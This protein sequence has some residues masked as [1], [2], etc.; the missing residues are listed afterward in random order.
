MTEKETN[1]KR[2]IETDDAPGAMRDDEELDLDDEL[3]LGLSQGDY[4]N[5]MRTL[6]D[7]I[8]LDTSAIGPSFIEQAAE[9]LKEFETRWLGQQKFFALLLIAKSVQ[10]Q[11]VIRATGLT[12]TGERVPLAVTQGVGEDAHVIKGMLKDIV[13]RGLAFE[14][15]PRF[16]IDGVKGIRSTVQEMFG[17]QVVIQYL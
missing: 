6:S 13:R 8:G 2:P 12:A 9:V 3:L 15:G 16:F 11:E 1:K 4:M 5:V 14:D 7:S 17:D 10:G